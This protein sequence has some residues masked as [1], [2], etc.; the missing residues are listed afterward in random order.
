MEIRQ[1][2]MGHLNQLCAEIEGALGAFPD[3][4]WRRQA[5]PD[6]LR[7]P[8]F[9]AHHTVWCMVLDHLL[10]IPGERLPHNIQPDYGPDK[11]MTQ[12]QLI[13]LLK[14]VQAYAADVYGEMPNAEYLASDDRGLSVLGRVMYTI[15]HTRHHY[16]QLVQILRDNGLEAPDWYPLR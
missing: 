11:P 7:V 8:C 10:R 16:G 3:E 9:L 13:Q 6:M 5:A 12:Q 14:D 2:V 1:E 15:A 4:L